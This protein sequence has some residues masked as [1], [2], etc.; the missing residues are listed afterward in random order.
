MPVKKA[1]RLA[2]DK[3]NKKFADIGLIIQ[4]AR[5]FTELAIAFQTL[6]Y[7]D[8]LDGYFTFY[9]DALFFNE[10][11][12]GTF[13]KAKKLA[14]NRFKD[15]EFEELKIPTEKQ[16]ITAQK[17]YKAAL[18]DFYVR[19]KLEQLPKGQRELV[20]RCLLGHLQPERKS[21]K[22]RKAEPRPVK[23]TPKGRKKKN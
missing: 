11:N 15:L 10:L 18:N 8:A 12:Y 7:A 13:K 16:A 23:A 6:R 5:S 3:K 20:R 1:T 21:A 14:Y 9:K 19:G 2:K 4:Q 17:R 22:L